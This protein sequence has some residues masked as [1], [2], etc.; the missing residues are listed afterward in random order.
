MQGVEG[1]EGCR[2]AI[3]TS[4]PYGWQTSM[5][6]RAARGCHPSALLLEILSGEV[7]LDHNHLF[8]DKTWQN[9]QLQS[10]FWGGGGD[11]AG[12]LF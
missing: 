8:C 7:L 2:R 10:S 6:C 9:Q 4:Y 5:H 3:G 11:V 12:S 1:Q